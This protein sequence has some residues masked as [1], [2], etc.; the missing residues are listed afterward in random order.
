M[1]LVVHYHSYPVCLFLSLPEDEDEASYLAQ[2]LMM[3]R[4]LLSSIDQ[5]V[6]PHIHKPHLCNLP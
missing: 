3:V 1:V 5:Q 6:P 4:E 2:C